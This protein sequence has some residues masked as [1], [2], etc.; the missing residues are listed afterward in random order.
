MIY[1]ICYPK[2]YSRLHQELVKTRQ[3]GYKIIYVKEES[4]VLQKQA[5]FH[6]IYT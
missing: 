1:L 2:W 6:C 4:K 5:S 3:F